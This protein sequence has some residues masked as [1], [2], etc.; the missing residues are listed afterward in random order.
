[1]YGETSAALRHALAELLR[2][3]RIAKPH[4]TIHDIR[5]APEHQAHRDDV[6]L[7]T[8]YRHTVLG[9]CYQT[10]R[11]LAPIHLPNTGPAFDLHEQ[12]HVAYATSHLAPGAPTID[13]LT[14]PHH[15]P[16]IERWRQAARAAVLAEADYNHGI[17]PGAH[18]NA[19]ALVIL[20]DIAEATCALA[21]LE[22][23]HRPLPVWPT[24]TD[25]PRLAHRAKFAILYA[26]Q[27]TTDH[28]V[29]HRGHQDTPPLEL[30]TDTPRHGIAGV[31]AAEHNLLV[32]LTRHFPD[33]TALR[34]VLDSQH[35]VSTVATR[36][37]PHHLD[38]LAN[39]WNTRAAL[40]RTL[41]KA[42]RDLGGH[43]GHGAPTASEVAALAHRL[44]HLEPDAS[45]T[46]RDAHRLDDT[47]A[48]L[49]ARIAATLQT[50]ARERLYFQRTTLPRINTAALGI[51]KPPRTRYTTLETEN[52]QLLT[53]A[54]S[55]LTPP[56]Q[57]AQTATRT[58]E[59]EHG[60]DELRT[61]LNHRLR[62]SDN[63][64][65]FQL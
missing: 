34:L 1:M 52:S 12:L 55:E 41:T 47:F 4:G 11:I 45:L 9:W 57:R 56:R 6:A 13:E 53:L 46:A 33:A 25:T 2:H 39:H 19:E 21:A 63:P 24:L 29:D 26:N 22:R 40:Y 30:V 16:V 61:Q 60:R 3:P 62:R 14:T 65:A 54:A 5:H 27:H 50:G 42:A 31:L 37:L 17:A 36:H 38:D 49:D 32:H 51:I 7:A 23:W 35:L 44:R 20:T 28:T 48:H 15:S 58:L 8:R 59:P 64:N 18:S 43:I 10:S